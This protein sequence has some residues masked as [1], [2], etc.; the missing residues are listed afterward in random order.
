MHDSLCLYRAEIL[1]FVQMLTTLYR[2][3]VH[4]L[5]TWR[6]ASLRRSCFRWET[7]RYLVYCST[8]HLFSF[9]LLSSFLFLEVVTWAQVGRQPG[10]RR[11]VGSS[12]P[13]FNAYN[14][15]HE[16]ALWP[17]STRLTGLPVCRLSWPASAGWKVCKSTQKIM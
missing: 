4:G 15:S 17:R 12:L 7:L 6:N 14:S 2:C 1:Q 13:L 8:L 5:V 3:F 16:P 11:Q 10:S 9:L